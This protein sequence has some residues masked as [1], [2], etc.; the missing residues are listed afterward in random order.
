MHTDPRHTYE[1]VSAV[2]AQA[3]IQIEVEASA[4][5]CRR[6]GAVLDPAAAAP[7]G[8]VAIDGIRCPTGAS[9]EGFGLTVTEAITNAN[10]TKF[11]IA[12]KVVDIEGGTT[13]TP[14]TLTLPNAAADVTI[15]NARASDGTPTTTQCVQIGARF[16]SSSTALP[17]LVPQG[18]V[19]YVEVT[20]AAGAAGGAVRPYL[21]MRHNGQENPGP[22]AKSPITSIAS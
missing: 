6:I 8:S 22:K 13:T 9:I 19:V 16:R 12:V 4:G 2:A 17:V 7:A 15:A 5:I 14:I 20:T 3:G 18:G 21:V 1:F 10:A 11:V